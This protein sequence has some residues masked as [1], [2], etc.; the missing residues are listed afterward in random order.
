[1]VI[2]GSKL[3]RPRRSI[4]PRLW[5]GACVLALGL[6]ATAHPIAAAPV[7]G[8]LPSISIDDVSVTE[9]DGGTVSATFTVTSS[10]RGKA[11]VSFA[12]RVGTAKSPADF[13]ARDGKVRFAGRKLER[14]VSITVNGD[15]LDEADETFEVVL[16]GPVGATIEDAVG[17]GTIEDDDPPPTASVPATASVP[18]GNAGDVSH[19]AVEFMLDAPSGRIVSVDFSTADGDATAGNDY[20]AKS[21]SV[22]FAPGETVRTMLVDVAGDGADEGDET[23]TLDLSA[24][25]HVELGND[26]TVITIVDN[27]PAP[28]GTAQLTIDGGQVREGKSGTKVIT[29]TVTRSGETTTAVTTGYSTSTGTA[30]D[31]D[32]QT[33]S[34]SLPFLANQTT[35]TFDVTVNGDKRLEHDEL[36]LANLES[37]S[38]GVAYLTPQATGQI[39]NDDTRTTVKARARASQV[40]ARGL[41]SPERE[42]RKVLVRL[43]RRKGGAW[44]LIG[45]RRPRLSGTSDVNA[46]GFTDSRYSTRFT[47]VKANRCKVKATYRGDGRFAPSTDTRTFRC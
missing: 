38:A 3:A 32:F 14:K 43:F 39:V 24:P 36:F 19:A 46:D 41:V 29:F 28:P 40:T 10:E 22:S 27:D 47:G 25:N 9:G 15:L 16:S 5:V 18:E 33:A 37:P 4:V 11:T 8:A 20:T 42:G 2:A 23:F 35:A 30:D 21:G 45:S 12:A 17:L 26:Q 34:G 1:M 7:R 6:S 13:V 44:D 31:D